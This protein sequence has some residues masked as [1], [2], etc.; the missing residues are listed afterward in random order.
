MGQLSNSSAR[1]NSKTK[2]TTREAT[3]VAVQS[4][5]LEAGI[6]TPV[7]EIILVPG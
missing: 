1:G 2:E 6:H 5:Q 3:A 7:A 4:A